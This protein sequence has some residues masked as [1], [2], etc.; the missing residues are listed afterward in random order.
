MQLWQSARA[1]T[2][3]EIHPDGQ[4]SPQLRSRVAKRVILKMMLYLHAC[5]DR[6]NVGHNVDVLNR[7]QAHLHR[8]VSGVCLTQQHQCELA[9]L[10]KSGGGASG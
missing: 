6:G 4:R 1:S 10:L 8:R 3:H 7:L 2:F 9:L 5:I